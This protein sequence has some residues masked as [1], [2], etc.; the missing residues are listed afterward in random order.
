[1]ALNTIDSDL[2]PVWRSIHDRGRNRCHDRAYGH[3]PDPDQYQSDDQITFSP[4]S[5]LEAIPTGAV[6][7]FQSQAG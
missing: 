6:L 2:V 5:G 1:M 3:G 4:A 7:T